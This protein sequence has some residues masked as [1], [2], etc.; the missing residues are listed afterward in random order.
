MP[1]SKKCTHPLVSVFL[2][3]ILEISRDSTRL[4]LTQSVSQCTQVFLSMFVSPLLKIEKLT[5]NCQFLIETLK[6]FASSSFDVPTSQ[7]PFYVVVKTLYSTIFEVLA[8][9]KDETQ[10]FRP[11]AAKVRKLEELVSLIHFSFVEVIC[12]DP[13]LFSVSPPRDSFRL[14]ADTQTLIREHAHFFDSNHLLSILKS[15]NHLSDSSL[16]FKKLSSFGPFFPPAT[17]NEHLLA[18]L[19]LIQSHDPDSTFA[20]LTSVLSDGRST[21]TPDFWAS[22][23]PHRH[24]D[25]YPRLFGL[26]MFENSEIVREV[27]SPNRPH[28]AEI[29]QEL[30]TSELLSTVPLAT[31]CSLSKFLLARPKET[32]AQLR[33]KF[34]GRMDLYNLSFGKLRLLMGNLYSFLKQATPELL[35]GLFDGP[36]VFTLFYT[37][38]DFYSHTKMNKGLLSKFSLVLRFLC[39]LGVLHLDFFYRNLT[40]PR[41]PSY[42]KCFAKYVSKGLRPEKKTFPLIIY[43]DNRVQPDCSLQGFVSLFADRVKTKNLDLPALT[44]FLQTGLDSKLGFPGFSRLLLEGFLGLFQNEPL[45]TL[46]GFLEK[47]FMLDPHAKNEGNRGLIRTFL[48]GF[49]FEHE[50]DFKTMTEFFLKAKERFGVDPS[51][52]RSTLDRSFQQ[53]VD[54]LPFDLVSLRRSSPEALRVNR[55]IDKIIRI[56]FETG[57]LSLLK[58]L[59]HVFSD[60]HNEFLRVFET[61]LTGVCSDSQ[62]PEADLEDYA[63]DLLDCVYLHAGGIF[64]DQ[65]YHRLNIFTYILVPVCNLLAGDSLVRLLAANFEDWLDCLHREPPSLLIACEASLRAANDHFL[66]QHMVLKLLALTFKKLEKGEILGK[67]YPLLQS[68]KYPCASVTKLLIKRATLLEVSL[69]TVH[70]VLVQLREQF[71]GFKLE[72]VELILYTHSV[73]FRASLFG[74]LSSLL[75]K[76]QSNLRIIADFLI[77]KG[78]GKNTPRVLKFLPP[79]L[80]LHFGVHT[81]FEIQSLND[82]GAS[83]MKSFKSSVMSQKFSAFQPKTPK[84][85]DSEARPG[86]VRRPID[87]ENSIELDD[88]NKLPISL[89]LIDLFSSVCFQFQLEKEI[90]ISALGQVFAA[91]GLK[92]HH[93]IVLLKVLVNNPANFEN[94][95]GV[96][97]PHILEFI[98]S[99]DTG[100]AGMHYFL[101]DLITLFCDWVCLDPTVLDP[102]P[103]LESKVSLAA[104]N[105]IKKLADKSR[106]V[107]IHN[108]DLFLKFVDCV[109]NH[110]SLDLQFFLKMLAI[111]VPVEKDA[112]SKNRREELR[113]WKFTGLCVIET[114]VFK[115]IRVSF[116]EKGITLQNPINS[117]KM[118]SM[119]RALVETLLEVIR[120]SPSRYLAFKAAS[121]LGM[122]LRRNPWVWAK[123]E[124]CNPLTA[125]LF[126]IRTR[127]KGFLFSMLNHLSFYYPRILFQTPEIRNLIQTSARKLSAQDVEVFLS[128]LFNLF[129]F[130]DDLSREFALHSNMLRIVFFDLVFFLEKT[131]NSG[132]K[133]NKSEFILV[134]LKKFLGVSFA[135]RLVCARH[136][137][138]R[139]AQMDI[140]EFPKEKRVFVHSLVLEVALLLKSQDESVPEEDAPPSF[141]TINSGLMASVNESFQRIEKLHFQK[142]DSP[143]KDGRY[144]ILLYF[145]GFCI[146]QFLCRLSKVVTEGNS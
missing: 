62:I 14:F 137:V 131:R 89:E 7:I 50:R 117:K 115:H 102:L 70:Q 133:F 103:D 17:F 68:E 51:G 121:V 132:A 125:S 129:E 80:G 25:F 81:Y 23:L 33:Q 2:E 58:H 74:C 122:F 54:E 91:S 5:A 76:T 59:F 45:E 75:M 71:F 130:G 98:C 48:E 139:L 64:P 10:R 18:A 56:S 32:F 128:C 143:E 37:I 90:A 127:S 21:T 67:L 146:L 69:D 30:F 26:F 120:G 11:P 39:K 107:A 92:L 53:M 28:F 77:F 136:L 1:A 15:L 138:D 52:F 9:A 100:G 4:S 55:V 87:K 141:A 38:D 123:A 101:R 40:N 95:K 104:K 116:R 110:L 63:R 126:S 134:L 19:P 114:L 8:N 145:M 72:M 86:S 73:H 20:R 124:L 6:L 99:K 88:V 112:D 57:E 60:R 142:E 3:S 82:L 111:Q 36:T 24:P 85:V 43:A 41:F 44:T 106:V 113:L 34:L 46:H 109:A 78:R 119:T 61:T 27:L 96:F 29:L 144:Y 135:E 105:I 140:A 16:V 66:R 47:L 42:T 94:H 31:F 93:K 118:P 12:H 108:F 97:L 84:S 83:L 13:K 22:P 79:S 65:F 35:R 49:D